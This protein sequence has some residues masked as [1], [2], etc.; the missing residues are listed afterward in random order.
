MHTKG[1]KNSKP[2]LNPYELNWSQNLDKATSSSNSLQPP[3]KYLD[4]HFKYNMN[5]KMAK[6]QVSKKN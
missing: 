6:T 3:N 2:K 5:K 1:N 4:V